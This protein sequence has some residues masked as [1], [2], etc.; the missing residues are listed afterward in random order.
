MPECKGCGA[1]VEEGAECAACGSSV[2]SGAT[3]SFAPIV[4]EDA[5]SSAQMDSVDGGAVLVVRKGPQTGE[6]FYVD[7]P[8]LTVGRDPAS[9]IFLNDMTVS[10]SHAFIEGAPGGVSIRDDGSLNG[11]YVNGVVVESTQLSDGD[12]VQIGTFQMVFL[13]GASV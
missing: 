13:E 4:S 9:D 6:R 8:R 5:T 12:I 2:S 3:E 10:R 11:T 1:L 7:R